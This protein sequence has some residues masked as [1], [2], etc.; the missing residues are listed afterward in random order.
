[1]RS[2]TRLALPPQRSLPLPSLPA[3]RIMAARAPSAGGDQPAPEPRTAI[4]P[5]AAASSPA[6]PAD[7]PDRA[8]TASA[9]PDLEISS[10]SLFAY[11][12]D[13]SGFFTD[14]RQDHEYASFYRQEQLLHQ[15]QQEALAQAQ[16]QQAQSVSSAVSNPHVL[17][18]QEHDRAISALRSSASEQQQQHHLPA[19]LPASSASLS[20]TSGSTFAGAARASDN[21]NRPAT[22]VDDPT[23]R[24][25]PVPATRSERP[26]LMQ[27]HQQSIVTETEASVVADRAN[28]DHS[29]S[30]DAAAVRFQKIQAQL[31]QQQQQD[32]ELQQQA[33]TAAAAD[34]IW[35]QLDQ[36]SISRDDD[37]P[38]YTPYN[39]P[40]ASSSAPALPI[41]SSNSAA[42]A[43]VAAA[44]VA[45]ASSSSQNLSRNHQLQQFHLEQLKL[46]QQQQQY[47]PQYPYQPAD[48]QAQA[49]AF[50]AA[51][52]AV[53][54]QQHKQH[55]GHGGIGQ[56]ASSPSG[57]ASSLLSEYQPSAANTN[58]S[59]P[60]INARSPVPISLL[61]YGAN[62][63]SGPSVNGS[64]QDYLSAQAAA[65]AAAA[66]AAVYEN[67]G[68]SLAG[69]RMNNSGGNSGGR[70]G[71]GGGGRTG[72]GY[73]S[74]NNHNG[75]RGGRGGMHGGG[76][77][78]Y[79]NNSKSSSYDSRNQRNGSGSGGG[80]GCHNPYRDLLGSSGPSSSSGMRSLGNG[81]GN[82]NVNSSNSGQN[83]GCNVSNGD[84]ANKYL[85]FNDVIGRAE[86]LARDQHGCRF[87]QTKLEEGNLSY[88]NAIFEEC[89]EKFVELMTDP[90]A[91]VSDVT[92]LWEAPSPR[93]SFWVP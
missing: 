10:R 84:P 7:L 25:S 45:Q 8:D 81:N 69:Y 3:T 48:L 56:Q 72:N 43:A 91:N 19:P 28:S 61:A 29:V 1:V 74:S 26:W 34:A 83:I 41:R 88:I 11:K 51:A 15:Q 22:V 52:A 78:S 86:E 70:N 85:S 71:S 42:A 58:G 30:A 40:T 93:C 50:A 55:H 89:Y 49:H 66:A 36:L 54:S 23:F 65:A 4:L 31:Q 47:T 24:P 20:S 87:L 68:R 12:T 35:N 75:S 82:G 38:T 9:P 92:Q 59:G 79:H 32:A 76:S 64:A 57:G 27:Q 90:F 13:Y 63:A 18:H 73:G 77:N 39:A 2:I 80:N 67:G 33:A 60:S 14:I 5:V 6:L 46:Q 44:A 21:A 53:A 62:S 17:S 16:A 37:A